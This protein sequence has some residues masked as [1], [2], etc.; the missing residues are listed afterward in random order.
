MC[1]LL[2]GWRSVVFETGEGRLET[3]LRRSPSV[4]GRQ[5]PTRS[6]PSPTFRKPDLQLSNAIASS[7]LAMPPAATFSTR[8]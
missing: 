4:R 2:V 6:S 7:G 8:V 1:S 3:A 5:L